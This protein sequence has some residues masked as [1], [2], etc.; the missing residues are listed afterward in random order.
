MDV[1]WPVTQG[2]SHIKRHWRHTL[3][4][5]ELGKQF[6]AKARKREY[7]EGWRKKQRDGVRCATHNVWGGSNLTRK[8]GYKGSTYG[9][10][11]E[12][13]TLVGEERLAVEAELKARG[14]L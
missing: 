8:R 2:T 7:Y 10:A 13:R 11:S 4:R 1:P 9:P 3:I 14:D 6:E 5:D 12:C